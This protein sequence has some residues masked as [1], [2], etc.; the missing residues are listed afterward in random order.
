MKHKNNTIGIYSHAVKANNNDMVTFM[1]INIGKQIITQ[2]TP[3]N[4]NLKI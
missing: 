3:T 4:K 1:I 2:N